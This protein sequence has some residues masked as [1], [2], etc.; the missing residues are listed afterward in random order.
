MHLPEGYELIATTRSDNIYLY[1]ELVSVVLIGNSQGIKITVI[2][3]LIASN[4]Y[5]TLYKVIVLPPCVSGYNFVRYSVDYSYIELSTIY[6]VYVVITEAYLRRCIIKRI[7]LCPADI[8]IHN[9]H[10]ISSEFIL[11]FQANISNTKCKRYLLYN[12]RIPIS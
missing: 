6:G 8:V 2:E 10:F 12:Y 9:T 3:P 7:T 11:L 5:F 4:E 1:Y